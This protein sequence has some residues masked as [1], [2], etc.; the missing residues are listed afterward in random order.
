MPHL[1]MA[2]LSAP[3]AVALSEPGLAAASMSEPGLAAGPPV[4]QA[5][6]PA[7]DTTLKMLAALITGILIGFI[8]SRL[9]L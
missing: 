2:P 7:N 3:G 9:L 8:L 1:P 4:G 5:A 6:A